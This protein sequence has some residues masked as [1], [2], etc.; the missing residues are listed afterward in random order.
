VGFDVGFELGLEVGFGLGFDVG[1][2]A[3]VVVVVPDAVVVDVMGVVVE[4]VFVVVDGDAVLGVGVGAE[5]C[6]SAPL[7]PAT[8]TAV[9]TPS[10][11]RSGRRLIGR[12]AGSRGCSRARPSAVPGW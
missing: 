2:G 12:S 11:Q 6:G 9:A 1:L 10:E 7:H 4:D 5:A 8:R 3:R